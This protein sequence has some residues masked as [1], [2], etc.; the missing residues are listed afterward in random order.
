MG[1]PEE[2]ENDIVGLLQMGENIPPSQNTFTFKWF[3]LG[4]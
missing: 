3:A 2:T 1:M 4:R